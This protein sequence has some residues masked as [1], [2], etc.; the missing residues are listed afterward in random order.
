MRRL[1]L[2]LV[3]AGCSY[4]E[5]AHDESNRSGWCFQQAQPPGRPFDEAAYLRCLYG[6][7]QA[8]DAGQEGGV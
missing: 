4:D 6:H 8:D 2:L 3:L 7:A 5:P 1:L